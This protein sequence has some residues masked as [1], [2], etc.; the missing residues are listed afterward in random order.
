MKRIG[1]AY[2]GNDGE[3]MHDSYNS[4]DYAAD[5]D[6]AEGMAEFLNMN[7]RDFAPFKIVRLLTDEIE[8]DK[9]I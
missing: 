2:E 6:E 9:Q 4:I 5:M 1:Y 8:D 3:L 7:F